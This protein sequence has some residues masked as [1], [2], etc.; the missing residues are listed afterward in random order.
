MGVNAFRTSHN[1]PSPELIDICQR[2]GIVMMVEAFD[3]WDVGKLSQDYHLYFNQ[4]SDY[5]I[6][7]MVNE[8]KNSPAVIMWSIGNEIPGFTSPQALPI[9]RRLIADIKSIDTTRPVVAGSD[10]YR[11]VPAPGSVADQMVKNLDGLG[12]N[13]DTAKAIDG[14]HAQYPNT[15]LFES[16]SS[17][18]TSTRG[19]YQDPDQLNTGQNFT[20]GKY[21][22]SSYDN[23]LASWTLSHEYG[24]KK[25][26]DRQYFAG[27]FLWSG[28]DYIGEPTPY[29]VFPVKTSF[30]G[31][32]DTAGFPKDAYY[33][34]QSQ[35]TQTP[36][37][38]LLPMNWNDYR[39]GQMV[40]VRAYANAPT[41]E[42]FLNGL[43][44]GTR[45]F[46]VKTSTDGTRYLETQQCPGDDENYTG[47]ACP[48]SYQSPNGSSGDLHLTWNVPFN[49]GRLVAVAR[50][51]AGHRRR[52]RRGRHCRASLRAAGDPGSHRHP[53]RRQVTLLPDRAGGRRPRSRGSR[54]RQHDPDVGQRRGYLP[55]GRQRQAGRRRGIPVADARRLQRQAGLD[56]AVPDEP[57]PG[58]GESLLAR[59]AAGHHDPLLQRPVGQ[60]ADRR[61]A[62]LH[63]RAPGRRARPPGD[64]GG[65]RC[66]RWH[67]V[68]PRAVELLAAE[69]PPGT[70]VVAGT[71]A[72]T[73]IGARAVLTVYDVARVQA[74]ST[75]VSVATP[76][77]PPATVNVTYTDGVTQQ[78]AVRWKHIK[79]RRYT[80][81]GRFT[82]RGW[83][84]A[85]GRR[86]RMRVIVTRHFN[87]GQDLALASGPEHPTADASFSGGVFSDGGSDGGTSTTVPSAMLD[88]NTTAGG[89]SNR[90]TKAATQTLPAVTASHPE[91]WVSVSW[92]QAQRFGQ[93]DVYYTLDSHN[94]LPASVTVTYWNGLAWVPVTG[95]QVSYASASDQPTTIS[96]DPVGTTAV[97]LDMT[98]RSPHDPTTGNLTIAEIRI[99]GDEIVPRR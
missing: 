80:G 99:P 76:P 54:R 88:G 51:A 23:N 96:F 2:L 98:S 75:T 10:K 11:S 56:R 7:E 50:D 26:R 28:W 64:G 68:A 71:V 73:G 89:W 57:W 79:P 9:E 27:Q 74:P 47:G 43:S 33:L 12:L 34:F 82:V 16:E 41:V 59:P 81:P 97:R 18:E 25:D 30:F 91:D 95:Q 92:P 1:P 15:F 6:K 20:P 78:L 39:P 87:T 86:V 66:R 69:Q 48:G 44:L 19:Y 36:M 37:V 5:D 70:Y 72:G 29:T 94:Q 4:W 61:S 35:W 21:E 38:H 17:S 83:I 8:A 22:V 55:G 52:P 53:R 32:V 67:P 93:L 77:T 24:L 58:H 62:G 45:S 65:R 63:P 60:W 49:P 3:A 85:I 42:L 14:L 31:A 46:A 40:Q 84:P 13:Y 90:Y